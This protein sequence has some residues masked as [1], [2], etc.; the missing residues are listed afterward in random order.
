MTHMKNEQTYR[1]L[2]AKMHEVAMVSPQTIG[3]FTPLYKRV[4]PFLKFSPWRSTILISMLTSA[5]LYIL[6]GSILVKIASTLQ[7]GF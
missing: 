5:V 3:P 1:L 7:F 6:L 4:V 2:V